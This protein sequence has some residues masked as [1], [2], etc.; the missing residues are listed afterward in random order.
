MFRRLSSPLVRQSQ[1]LRSARLVSETFPFPDTNT[2]VQ[3]HIGPRDAE[4]QK[5]LQTLG[6]KSLDDFVFQTIP[7]S[8]RAKSPL[9]ST[10]PVPEHQALAQLKAMASK[11][12]LKK[13]FLG[14]G[15]H[16][17]VI[18][19]ALLRNVIENPDWYTPYTPYQAEIAQGRLETLLMYQDV[20]RELT[21]LPYANA[22]LLDEGT[23]AAEAMLVAFLRHKRKRK[24]FL[25]SSGAHP[26]VLEVLRTRAAGYG[27]DLKIVPTE[28]MKSHIDSPASATICGL[29]IPYPD[30]HGAVCTSVEPLIQAS[31]AKGVV[32]IVT[33]DLM[34]LTIVK[35]PGE[36]G[37]DMCVGNSQR[38]GVPLGCGGPH[39]AFFA[40]GETDVRTLPGRLIGV[41]KDRHGKVAFRMA[42]Q[43]REQHIKRERATSNICTAQALLAN[44]AAFYAIY[45]GPDGLKAIA[46]RLHKMAK[47]LAV[48]FTKAGHKIPQPFFFD[49]V[50]I[51]LVGIS[52]DTYRDRVLEKGIN[53]R[54]D[55]P[56]RVTIALDETANDADLVALLSAATSGPVNLAAL[57]AEA[58]ASATF[59]LPPSLT[60]TTPFLQHEVF[61][62]HHSEMEFQR[63]TKRLV[64]KDLG[65][66]NSSIPLGSCTLK[67][68]AA[69]EMMAL[70]WPEFGNIHPFCPADQ[71][72]GFQALV[73]SLS[74]YLCAVTGFDKCYMAPNSGAQGEYAGLLTIRNYQRAH[75]QGDRNI[76]LIPISAHGTNPASATMCGLDLDII[77]CD[78]S[79][80]LIISDLKAK[81]EKHKG[82]VSCMMITYPSTYGV[83]ED[84][85]EEITSLVHAAGAQVYIDGANMN[86][87]VGLTAP[88]LYGGDVC[89]LNLHKTF[90]I[91]HG[92]GGPGMGPICVKKHLASHLPTGISS[93]P[94]GSALVLTISWM[95]V[96]MMG[97]SGLVKASQVALLNANYLMHRL[98]SKY[99]ILFK[100][101]NGRCAHEFIVDLR[102][103]KKSAGIEAEDVAKRL[104][105]YS[106]HAPTLSFPVVGTLMIEPT[107][108]ES[109][110]EV[111]RL[112]QAL[113]SIYDEINEIE[114]G[115]AD[116]TN[117]LLKNAP[118]SMTTLLEPWN[119]PYSIE[120]A[121]F[122]NEFVKAHKF[123]PGCGRI[124][125]A[126]G[127]RRLCCT[128][129]Q[130]LA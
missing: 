123:W 14:L 38:F 85:I 91:P 80:R 28:E 129:P 66:R 29:L 5:M 58:D 104:M 2:F 4:I 26:H 110:F 113:L 92:G 124:D 78:L 98:S 81:L 23:A 117:N 118:H 111:E 10:T 59:R 74:A 42:L 109:L 96:T 62:N 13:S 128:L 114:R 63:L 107:E 94:W 83:F 120:K 49:T 127:D 106:F 31:K 82:K 19:S 22:S 48:G 25:A 115:V 93:G 75:G 68:N 70:S 72:L 50:S 79:G 9:L 101:E 90:A 119:Y 30:T 84:N 7:S 88:A 126:Y 51:N 112:A 34:A 21:G 71:K 86:A 16:Q 35:P 54:V 122:P 32:N 37:A 43:A 18:P 97:G 76:C 15:Y 56:N 65:L 24:T 45:H 95:Y 36:L 46:S 130:D 89:H 99:T 87:Q 20:I 57:S 60:R 11:N 12:V 52:A 108:S 6:A 69:A 116:K 53:V 55:A 67:L 100:N 39:A 3:R 105:D 27:I 125:N 47:T 64:D 103:F 41:S 102:P 40:V 73:D 1:F 44:V 8:I 61:Q 121:L 17:A 33:S 77:D